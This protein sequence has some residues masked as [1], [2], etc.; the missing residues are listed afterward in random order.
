[1]QIFVKNMKLGDGESIPKWSI[2]ELQGDLEACDSDGLAGKFIGDLHFTK[3]NI[4]I[5]VIGHHI[6]HGK[7]E[8]VDPPLAVVKKLP[9]SSSSGNLNSKNEEREDHPAYVVQ[10]LV[11]RK[12]FFKGRP[13]PIITNVPKQV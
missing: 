13:R 7:V 3:D 8:K 12:L 10:G 9:S 11:T 4:P 6:L 2:I 5:L 1:M